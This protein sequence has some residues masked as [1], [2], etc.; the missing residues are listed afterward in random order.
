MEDS[1]M[2]TVTVEYDGR[3]L[4]FKK[5]L[6]AFV[7]LGAKVSTP[8][9]EL[10]GIEKSLLDEEQGRVKTYNSVDDFFKKNNLL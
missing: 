7:A 3:N 2:A 6:E 8:K 1:I 10:S 5:L 4:A 9:K